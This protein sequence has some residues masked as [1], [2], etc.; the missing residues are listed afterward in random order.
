M[1]YYSIPMIELRFGWWFCDSSYEVLQVVLSSVPSCF[2]VPRTWTSHLWWESATSLSSFIGLSLCVARNKLT[3]CN[4]SFLM[5]RCPVRCFKNNLQ[6]CN[7]FFFWYCSALLGEWIWSCCCKIFLQEMRIEM[8]LFFFNV[9]V[10][11]K[12]C[13]NR[14]FWLL[15]LLF[16]DVAENWRQKKWWCST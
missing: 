2:F 15:Q 12:I 13:C 14:S 10:T 11:V 16:L 3:S 4:S 7:D 1:A 8:S 5:F 6:C 9:A